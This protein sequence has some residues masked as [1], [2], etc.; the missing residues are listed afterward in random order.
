MIYLT[1]QIAR[2]TKN[3]EEGDII[4]ILIISKVHTFLVGIIMMAILLC[5]SSQVQ[6]SQ[7]GDYEYSVTD[8][9]AQITLYTGAGGVVTIPSNLGGFPV[10]SIDDCAF[11]YYTN[12][13][14]III[15]QGLTNIGNSAFAGC[16]RLTSI[17]IPQ[18]VKSI[19]GGAFY[20][21]LGLD[22]IR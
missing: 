20:K 3:M 18:G 8:G 14:S 21:C 5:C 17:T 6:A 4:R 16:S 7:D 1:D 15:P 13:T 10:T 11:F 12:I 2:L 9:N 19:G 22:S